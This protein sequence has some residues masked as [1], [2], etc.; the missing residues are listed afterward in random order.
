[1]V[2]W[3]STKPGSSVDIVKNP[4]GQKDDNYH[5]GEE[6]EGK[7][8]NEAVVSYSGTQPLGLEAN[9]DSATNMETG[10]PVIDRQLTEYRHVL[11]KEV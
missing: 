7:D 4:I 11:L 6:T 1:M 10:R 3:L 5:G 9:A 2:N 8:R